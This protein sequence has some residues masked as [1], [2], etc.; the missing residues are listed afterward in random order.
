MKLFKQIIATLL[1]AGTAGSGTLFANKTQ[2]SNNTKLAA[3]SQAIREQRASK[4]DASDSPIKVVHFEN[5]IPQF[6]QLDG[7]FSDP[8][9]PEY[10]ELEK[11]LKHFDFLIDGNPIPA[12]ESRPIAIQKGRPFTF[13][14]KTKPGFSSPYAMA[15]I[16]LHG[17]K[18]N[19][20]L[21]ED[22]IHHNNKI[23]MDELV[24]KH[25]AMREIL[26]NPSS[27]MSKIK[28][29]LTWSGWFGVEAHLP[30][31]ESENS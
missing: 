9:H 3:I 26:T 29:Y 22:D 1:V 27:I 11:F 24:Y 5:N 7:K 6:L 8:S 4:R 2:A 15:A 30:D 25:P 23:F 20:V 14:I 17:I 31:L 18:Y 12:Y 28:Q 19:C 13:S 21:H 16:L 10:I